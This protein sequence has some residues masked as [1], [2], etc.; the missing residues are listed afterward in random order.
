M[1]MIR[2]EIRAIIEAAVK[3]AFGNIVVPDFST[4]V[5]EN[6][7]HGDYATNVAL[8]L[9]RIVKKNPMEIAEVLARQLAMYNPQLITNVAHPGFINFRL[10]DI[11][12][13]KEL[14]EILKKKNA[15]G[16]QR[17]A[18][19]SQKVQIEFISANPTGALT[20][21]NGRGAFLGDV[22][23]N[24]LTK[25][26]YRVTREYYINN[27]RAST[28][29][30]ELGKTGLEKGT[31]YLTP[32]LQR[33]MVKCNKKIDALKKKSPKN[34]DGEVG[35]LLAQEIQKENKRFITNT[36]KIK[37]DSWFEEEALYTK[38][39]PERILGELTK[40]GY[41]Y[42]KDGAVWFRATKFGDSEDRV[43]IR[44][45]G[46]PA[47]L[48]PDL[49]YHK[50]KFSGRKFSRAIDIWGADHH[51]YV[52]RLKAGLQALGIPAEPL[53][54]IITQLVRLIKDGEEVKMSKRAGTAILFSD[55]IKEVGLD[56]AR[57]FFLMHSSD[58]HMDFDMT[59]AQERS[60]KNPVYY[61]QYALVR[62]HSILRKR[63]TLNA[64]CQTID[65]KSK[66][67]EI[68]NTAEERALLKKL[69]QFPE[70]VGDTAMDYQ[71]H[72]LTR[73]GM[74]LAAGFHHFYEKHRVITE[75]TAKSEARL[76]LVAAT[77]IVLHS[78]LDLL[79]I[80]QPERM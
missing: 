53:T 12:L 59:I 4:A 7:E 21:G 28:Q 44:S 74:E 42:K 5:P 63:Q 32:E 23:A 50:D 47:Y 69:I 80:S 8:L 40:T 51:G 38:K 1:I 11:V 27:A 68:L 55:L 13:Q 66:I 67:I 6:P 16:S 29:I 25:A 54:V 70:V 14:S 58:T 46:D 45:D 56:G 24:T 64:K 15:Y 76:V 10:S 79:G 3:S 52:P 26:G 37:F 18:A 34:L 48:L 57:F 22:L 61:V 73:Y 9:A 49:A 77:K 72:R 30:K 36:L 62:C 39:L 71:V 78:L 65:K 60:M 75:D 19:N 33:V 35:H 2:S 31:T 41:A 17:G 43:L 20:I